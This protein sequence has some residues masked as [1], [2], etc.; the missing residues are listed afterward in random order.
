MSKVLIVEDDVALSDSLEQILSADGFTID[1]VIDGAE[2]DEYLKT[3]T[4]E[5]II[6]DWDVPS[7][8]GVELCRRY[9]QR[10]G[11]CPIL[12]LTGKSAIAEKEEGLDAG[13]DDY[14]TKP[15]HPRE[16]R[17]RIRAL[18]R[19]PRQLSGDKLSVRDI[20]FDPVKRE[21]S[22]DGKYV[23]LTSLEIDLFEFFMRHPG[24]VFS[25]EALVRGVWQS[26]AEISDDAIYAAIKRL[27]RKLDSSG[28]TSVITNVHGLGYR[29]DK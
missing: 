19:R 25:I 15:F 23:K 17:A 26:E 18:L 11:V 22:R 13:A 2:G 24:E 29:L 28:K 20:D 9:R 4:Y 27:R 5:L 8:S 1:S 10:G 3:Y 6:L 12:L 21:V 16:L 7:L 14:L